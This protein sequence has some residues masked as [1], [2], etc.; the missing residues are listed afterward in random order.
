MKTVVSILSVLFLLPFAVIA[1]RENS[2]CLEQTKN[3]DSADAVILSVCNKASGMT[4][5]PRLRLYFRLYQSGRVEY[6]I[7]PGFNPQA[8]ESN[9]KLILKNT[10]IDAKEVAEIVRLGTEPDFQNAK[11]EY[12]IFQIWTDS[13]LETTI[14]FKHQ[15]AEKKIVVNNYSSSDKK[16]EKHYPSSLLKMLQKIDELRPKDR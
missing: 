14:I 10:K 5:I 3:D 7:N 6:E 2:V 9:F 11:S 16:N 15:T 4:G 1:Q 12:P 8:G 13:G